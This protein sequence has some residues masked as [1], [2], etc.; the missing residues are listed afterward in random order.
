MSLNFETFNHA[1]MRDINQQNGFAADV[2][3]WDLRY[4]HA[5][6]AFLIKSFHFVEQTAMQSSWSSVRALCYSVLANAV[7]IF[8][9]SKLRPHF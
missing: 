8:D 2:E 7:K 4:I 5:R 1:H 9:Y 6:T 3:C